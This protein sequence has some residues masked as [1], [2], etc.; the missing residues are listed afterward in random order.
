[1]G[2][3]FFSFLSVYELKACV[4]ICSDDKTNCCETDVMKSL[5]SDDWSPN[6]LENWGPKFFG[7]CKY[8]KKSLMP[9]GRNFRQISQK[10]CKKFCFF[11]H[12]STVNIWYTRMLFKLH[13]YIFTIKTFLSGRILV[14]LARKFTGNW[15][16]CLR[17]HVPTV[18][19]YLP[20]SHWFFTR[21][22]MEKCFQ[23]LFFFYR[24]LSFTSLCKNSTITWGP[25]Y[26][27]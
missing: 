1:M 23:L 22:R 16:H 10:G 11:I 2:K 14:N 8:V 17:S 13:R 15:Q 26:A 12:L 3:I 6:D 19:K 18:F 21:E 4:Q 7:A 27:E 20:Q 9:T 5:L 25:F 24:K